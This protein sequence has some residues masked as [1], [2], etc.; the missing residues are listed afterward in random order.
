[1]IKQLLAPLLLAVS[2]LASAEPGVEN[3]RI[4][5]GQSAVLSGPL[6]ENGVQYM[7]GIQLYFDQI[8]KKGGVHGRKL[9]LV[10][11]DDTYNPK[12]AEENTRQLIEEKQVFALFGY[13]GTGSTAAALPLAEEQQVPLVAPYT[14]A[15]SL[16][17]KV[18]PVL[19]HLR[20]GYGEEMRKIVEHQTTL[21][22]RQ[23]AIVYQDDNFGKAGL[24][25]FEAAMQQYGLK[26]AGVYAVDPARLAESTAAS[27]AE[28][29]KLRPMAVVLATA[30]K[31]SSAVIAESIKRGVRPQFIG[32]SAVSAAQLVG[33]LKNEAA[34]VIVAQTM[35]SPWSGKHRIVRQ[36]REALTEQGGEPHYVSLEGYIA[37]RLMADAL[38]RTGKNPTRSGLLNALGETR[39]LDLGDFVIDYSNGRH[40]GSTH[41]DLS[42]IRSNGQFMQ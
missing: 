42:M 39:Q 9:E 32:L 14:G 18:S 6:A 38:R 22:I 37:A 4:L 34:G 20:P 23:I 33:E 29:Q 10:S 7:R 17:D 41:V 30:G 13:T 35:P 24:K 27:A 11:L 12:K 40:I 25:G 28:L 26:P 5:L 1:M 16:R 2:C 15:D 36:Y 21:G 3:N 8:N 31:V 19:Y